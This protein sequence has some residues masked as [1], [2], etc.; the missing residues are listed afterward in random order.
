MARV[1]IVAAVLAIAFSR[2]AS[3][4]LLPL[5]GLLT[6]LAAG[7]AA[8]S[9]ANVSRSRILTNDG[10]FI[11]LGAE[12]QVAGLLF[13]RAVRGALPRLQVAAGLPSQFDQGR[14]DDQ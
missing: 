3:Q 1:L 14:I 10:L 13:A 9:L 2:I 5:D 12:K 11:A 6:L 8:V 4:V 7:A